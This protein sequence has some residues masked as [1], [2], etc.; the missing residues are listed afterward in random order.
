ML[1]IYRNLLSVTINYGNMLIQYNN[2]LV[3][4]DYHAMC[5]K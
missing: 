1:L 4:S 2:L 5:M 3:T